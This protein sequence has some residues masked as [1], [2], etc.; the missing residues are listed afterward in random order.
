[1]DAYLAG[2]PT[3]LPRPRAD[4]MPVPWITRI[5]PEGPAWKRV[6]DY[7]ILECQELWKCQVCGED[8]PRRAWII[9]DPDGAVVSNSAMHLPC[10]KM[11]RRWCPHL[12]D[13]DETPA[14]E[15]TQSQILVDWRWRLN[16]IADYGE[17]TREWSLAPDDGDGHRT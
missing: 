10:L 14:V 4:G 15:V 5:D 11:A 12:R 6:I 3:G 1:M 16:T 9:L 17:E 7:R 2:T 13:E 8:L